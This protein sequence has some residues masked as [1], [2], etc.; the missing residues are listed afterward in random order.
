MPEVVAAHH[1]VA[2]A[3]TRGT[4]TK[5]DTCERCAQPRR[6]DG[7]HDDYGQPLK[8]RWLCRTCHRAVH[9]EKQAA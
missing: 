8:V 3:L 6:L 1:A 9:L 2:L 5:P 4:L 7:H